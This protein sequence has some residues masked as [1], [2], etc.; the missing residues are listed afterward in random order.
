[1]VQFESKNHNTN[2]EIAESIRVKGTVQGVGFRPTVYRLAK[3][4]QLRGEVS[5]DGQGV[6][7]VVVGDR[8]SINNF[9]QQLEQEKPPLARITDRIRQKKAEKSNFTDFTI[10]KS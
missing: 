8:S 4:N 10:V 1:M 5:N 7:I 3:S 2:S 9:I 6:L